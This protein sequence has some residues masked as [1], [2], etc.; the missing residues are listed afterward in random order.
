MGWRLTC[1][2]NVCGVQCEEVKEVKLL[3]LLGG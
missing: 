2:V 3:L 1:A